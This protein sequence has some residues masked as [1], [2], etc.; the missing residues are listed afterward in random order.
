MAD[1]FEIFNKIAKKEEISSL[2]IE[3][4]VVGLGNPGKEYE[5]TR[6]NAGYIYIDRIA[7][8]C[9]KRI[10]R[11]KFSSLVC[12]AVFGGKRVLLMKP[13]TFMNLSGKAVAEA[14]NFYKIPIEKIVVISDDISLDVGRMRVRRN[15]SHG[16]QRGLLS[17]EEHMASRNYPRIKI[18]V[19]QKPHPEY[20]LAAWVLSE[21]TKA[22]MT[23]LENNFDAAFTGLEKILSGDIDG[24]MQICNSK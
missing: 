23:V 22:E 20:D 2:P 3:Y 18:G 12:D 1:I 24:A 19:G 10:D 13:Q 15:G 14:S 21:F 7:E 11:A 9:G 16:G 6:H 5:R 4:L 8:K 17:I